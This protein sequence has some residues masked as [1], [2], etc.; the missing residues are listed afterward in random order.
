VLVGLI[1]IGNKNLVHIGRV[2][3][4]Y[5]VAKLGRGRKGKVKGIVRG[6]IRA[7]KGDDEVVGVAG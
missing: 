6:L 1:I 3:G 7:V 5:K 2:E 4:K